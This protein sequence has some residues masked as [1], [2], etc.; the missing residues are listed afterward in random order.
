MKHTKNFII[1]S[2]MLVF[3]L[4]S[5]TMSAQNAKKSK[6]EKVTI[7]TSAICGDCKQRLERN[8]AFEKGVKSVSLDDETKV[9]TIEYRTNKTDKEKLKKAITKIGYDA[10]ELEADPKAYERLPACCKKDNEP[11]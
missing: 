8:I 2:F 3:M 9:L 10:D 11:H 6:T 1:G 7:Q 4:A 5:L